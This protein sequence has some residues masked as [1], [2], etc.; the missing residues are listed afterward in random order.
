MSK[1][2][3]RLRGAA[4]RRPAPLGFA[5]R[6]RAGASARR[7]L[8][9][10]AVSGANEAARAA[11][12]GADALL[13]RGA[14]EDGAADLAAL[15]A[16]VEAA[17]G[18]PLGALV[19]A[20]APAD[21]DALIGAGADFL[22]FDPDR[23]EAAALL[24]SGLGHVAALPEALA[25]PE[26]PADALRLLQPLDLDAILIPPPPEGA[27]T[28]RGQLLVRRVADL[29]GKPLIAP[30]DASSDALRLEVWRDAGAAAAL[31]GVW[32]LSAVLAA[33]DAVPPPRER[34]DARPDALVP[35]V[36]PEGPGGE[37]DDLPF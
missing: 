35:S 22:V 3:D 1:L 23:A 18:V 7:V 8:V 2:R 4:S 26:A 34:R 19:P 32:A 10:A 17:S 33:A 14:G 28:V 31:A 20:A 6:D 25:A 9:V 16:T 11:A 30:A 21:A 12:S 15:A 27:P 13:L 24:R 5:P 37:D 29:A 36:A